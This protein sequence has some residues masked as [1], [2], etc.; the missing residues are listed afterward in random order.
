MEKKLFYIMTIGAIGALVLG[1]W[2]VSA[3]P[4]SVVSRTL[5]W[6]HVKL[7][8]VAVAL[9]FHL[10]CYRVLATFSRDNEHHTHVFFRWINEVPAL[11]LLAILIL[12][13]VKPF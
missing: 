9:G 11:I 6:L 8:L 1:G 2:L 12:T 3:Y 4:W 10:Y 13:I 5:G 7:I